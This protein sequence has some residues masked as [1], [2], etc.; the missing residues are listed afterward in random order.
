MLILLL[1]R[2]GSLI[3]VSAA[4]IGNGEVLVVAPVD[5]GVSTSIGAGPCCGA[6]SSSRFVPASV[7]GCDPWACTSVVAAVVVAPVVPTCSPLSTKSGVV[8]SGSDSPYRDQGTPLT[9]PNSVRSAISLGGSR[10]SDLHRRI[11]VA[12]PMKFSS[13]VVHRPSQMP[14]SQV[15]SVLPPSVFGSL[16]SSVSA[17]FTIGL[18]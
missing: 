18:T 14:F 2:G 4:T 9:L 6:V 7:V 17:N 13:L 3:V 8:N 5:D 12:V 15:G 11:S 16:Y 1:T 10:R